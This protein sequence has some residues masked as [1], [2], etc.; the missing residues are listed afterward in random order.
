MRVD[1]AQGVIDL[2]ARFHPDRMEAT[3]SVSPNDG[4]PETQTFQDW[5][6]ATRQM[7][8]FV[9]A[10]RGDVDADYAGAPKA[11]EMLAVTLCAREAAK[12]GT[13]VTIPS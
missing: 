4:L 5:D 3:I 7:E 6:S 13:R 9:A 10:I 2:L 12:T 11:I 8:H 1:M